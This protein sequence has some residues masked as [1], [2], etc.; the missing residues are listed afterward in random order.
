MTL[1]EFFENLREVRNLFDW[2]VEPDTGW[3]TDGRVA[4]RGWI[5][6][7]PRTGPAAGALL[8]PMGAVCY[9][10]TGKAYGEKS[11][12]AAARELRLDA[13]LAGELDAASNARTWSGG[14]GERR[15]V[16]HLKV[17]RD[18]LIDALGLAVHR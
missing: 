10:L 14:A 6:G 1:E 17:L 15:P 16:P 11:W 3:Y 5:R 13:S 8:E 12:K 7:R 2:N 9:V 18:R 4:R